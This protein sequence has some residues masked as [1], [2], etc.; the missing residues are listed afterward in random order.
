MVV[1]VC[2]SVF[3]KPYSNPPISTIKIQ[4][5]DEDVLETP[6]KYVNALLKYLS[7]NYELSKRRRNVIKFSDFRISYYSAEF[8]AIKPK[9]NAHNFMDC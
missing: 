5:D 1:F 4:G 7:T 2:T 9:E 6:T 3:R 8:T